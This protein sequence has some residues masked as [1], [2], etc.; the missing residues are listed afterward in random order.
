MAHGA[1]NRREMNQAAAEA[2][3][4]RIQ[5]DAEPLQRKLSQQS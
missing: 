1:G 4:K 5:G 3:R 2:A